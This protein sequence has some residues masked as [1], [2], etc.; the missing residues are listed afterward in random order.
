MSAYFKDKVVIV[1]GGTD[2]I[3][4]ALVDALISKALRLPPAAAI[5]INFTNCIQNMR[6]RHYTQWYA[7]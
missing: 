4:K 2:G 6:Q 7:M 5:L 1:T 3:G